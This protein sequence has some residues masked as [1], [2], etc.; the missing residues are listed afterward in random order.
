MR[1]LT[2]S[3]IAAERVVALVPNAAARAGDAHVEIVL[4][5]QTRGD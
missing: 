1:L 4:V 3:G 2:D 5:L